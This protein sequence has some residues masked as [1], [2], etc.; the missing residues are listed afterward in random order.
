MFNLA[1][2][3]LKTVDIPAR[4]T[5]SCC[6]GGKNFDE[7]YVTCGV[8]GSTKGEREKYPMTG[9]VFRVTGLRVRGRP[10]NVYEG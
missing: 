2:K 4:R 1:G 7:L 9:S 6:F 8:Q 5:T 10:A 3:Q